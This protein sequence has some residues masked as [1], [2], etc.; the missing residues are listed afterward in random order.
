[1]V[2]EVSGANAAESISDSS[3]AAEQVAVSEFA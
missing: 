1:M 2:S 3:A